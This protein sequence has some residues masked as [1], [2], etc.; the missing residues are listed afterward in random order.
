MYQEHH[1]EVVAYDH[2]AGCQHR[3]IDKQLNEDEGSRSLAFCSH[4]SAKTTT[5]DEP[6]KLQKK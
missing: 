6:L 3:E 5:S 2:T 4:V 1:T